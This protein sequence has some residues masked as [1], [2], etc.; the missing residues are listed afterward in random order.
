MRVELNSAARKWCLFATGMTVALAIAVF[1]A[2]QFLAVLFSGQPNVAHLR[3]AAWLQP[4]NAEYRYQLGVFYQETDPSSAVKWFRSAA[5][6]N[7]HDAGYW[8]HLASVYH[9]SRDTVSET[10]A[11]QQAADAAPNSAA[12]AWEVANNY[13]A[14]GDGNRALR[15]FR[16]VLAQGRIGETVQRCWKIRPD[17]DFLLTYVFP[18]RTEVYENFAELLMRNQDE[19]NAARVWQEMLRINQPIQQQFVL[20]YM[21]F[22]LS[23]RH[24]DQALQI[25]R[26]AASLASLVDYQPSS[27]NLVVNG[28][29]SLPVLNGGLDW[30]YHKLGMVSLA[31]DPSQF[32]VAPHSL[33]IDFDRAQISDAGVYHLIPV[34]PNTEYEFSAYY[35][36]EALEGAGGPEF[37]LQDALTAAPYFSSDELVDADFWKQ[38]DGN[39]KT[40]PQTKLLLLSIQRVP[41]GD[42]I[43]GK[44]WVDA[45]ELNP[46]GPEEDSQ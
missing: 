20:A 14:L 5:A 24:V 8:L 35:K 31:L 2:V 3:D 16:V 40:G 29:F 18:P 36:T 33:L 11:L 10:S 13:M 45:V 21:N 30:F 37:V 19:L 6:L 23:H 1:S 32:F 46:R 39:F 15:E 42:V 38:V 28:D 41:A 25:W 34:E 7:P 22:A 9:Y 4:G 26:Q 44:L 27:G 17:A 12:V 43:K